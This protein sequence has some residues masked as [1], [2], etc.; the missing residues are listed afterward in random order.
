[1]RVLT[2]ITFSSLFTLSLYASYRV[3][4]VL[5]RQWTS[6]LRILPGPKSRN[7]L[8]GNTIELLSSLSNINALME[9]WF[10]KYGSTLKF[11]GLLNG[12][13]IATRD[14][15]AMAHILARS[16]I[17][18]KSED[19]RKAGARIL[20]EGLL[21]AEGEGHRK[22]RKTMN[23]AF[24]P[25]QIRALTGVFTEKANILRDRIDECISAENIEGTRVDMLSWL[26][27]A[28]LDVIGQAGFNYRF[29]ALDPSL[30][31]NEFNVLFTN[32][33]N[34][35]QEASIIAS[36]QDT[37]PI[38]RVI[39]S[40][41]EKQIVLSQKT[42]DRIGQELL[43]AAKASVAADESTG[44][45][46][47]GRDLLTLLV[48]ANQEEGTAQK[49]SD[50]EVL[51][52]VPTFLIAGHETTTSATAWALFA[53]TQHPAIQT[54]LREEC[55]SL[56]TDEPSMEQLDKLSYLE[57][58]VRETMRVYAPVP[59]AA[60]YA[61]QDDVIPLE[62]P[63]VDT[64]GVE[65]HEFRVSKGDNIFVV[66]SSS[67]SA[68]DLWGPDAASF[69]PERWEAG[70]EFMIPKGVPGVWGNQMSFLGGPRGCIGFRFA[71]VEMKALLYAL[72]RA[73]E[74]ELAVPAANIVPKL[75]IV[76][77]PTVSSEPEIA[78][79]MPLLVKPYRAS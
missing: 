26:S 56:A 73:F 71:V 34:C 5:C 57:C 35:I 58:V 40:K 61:M 48:K 12:Y 17:Y 37:F 46:L 75:S 74:F 79:Q 62:Q 8:L 47:E 36:L 20:G 68:R 4:K 7:P 18:Q 25:A 38:L 16:D 76:L 11:H 9:K 31:P 29:D 59:V 42:M 21:L 24:G 13:A 6:P 43:V 30:P 41:R 77:N 78:K 51:G 50:A 70:N 66:I 28:T 44:S 32:L 2:Q 14:N 52:Q 10:D 72:V 67:N 33:S 39:P 45:G 53:L 23:P 19:A 27:K 3:I 55:L 60:R 65:H 64:K 63:F 22:Q 15:R 1:M 69:R 54:K 49:L